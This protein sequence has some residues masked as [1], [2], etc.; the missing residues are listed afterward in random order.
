MAGAARGRKKEKEE[1]I[2]DL[3]TSAAAG[4]R[5]SRR[6]SRIAKIR[7]EHAHE[8]ISNDPPFRYRP[9]N[10]TAFLL[11]PFPPAA[12]ARVA[13]KKKKKKKRKKKGTKKRKNQSVTFSLTEI[14]VAK[15]S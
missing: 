2:Q 8:R 11:L 10:V 12:Y 4:E 6:K 13:K 7:V 9:P 5:A 15:L 3:L 14:R 1:G